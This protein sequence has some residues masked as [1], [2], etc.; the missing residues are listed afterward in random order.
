MMPSNMATSSALCFSGRVSVTTA[1]W[2]ATSTLTRSWVAG[3]EVGIRP[4]DYREDPNPSGRRLL[5]PVPVELPIAP[6]GVEQLVVGSLL[7]DPA[8]LEHDDPACVADRREPVG[9]DDRG[10]VRHQPAQS[11]LDQRLRV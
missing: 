7:D 10:S 1:T 9:D 3:G 11:L 4:G 5:R 8:V 2:S 6:L